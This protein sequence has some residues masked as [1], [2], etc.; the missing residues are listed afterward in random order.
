[1][2]WAHDQHHLI[3]YMQNKEQHPRR[4]AGSF[5]HFCRYFTPHV[6]KLCGEVMAESCSVVIHC[7]RLVNTQKVN[8]FQSVSKYI[9]LKSVQFVQPEEAFSVFTPRDPLH[10]NIHQYWPPPHPQ[11]NR[12]C[13]NLDFLV[14]ARGLLIHHQ[15]ASDVTE[16]V[17]TTVQEQERPGNRRDLSLDAGHSSHQLHGERHTHPAAVVQLISIIRLHLGRDTQTKT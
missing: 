14:R 1:M 5:S 4:G 2:G 9:L 15:R 6:H 12:I 13:P 16:L 10:P 11:G 3:L 8:C 7:K 17:V